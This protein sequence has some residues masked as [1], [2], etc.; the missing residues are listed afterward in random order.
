MKK[1]ILGTV[2]KKMILSLLMI[3][4]M[5]SSFLDATP[6]H[7]AVENN[8]IKTVRKLIKKGADVNSYD[9]YLQYT[10]LH[11]AAQENNVEIALYLIDHGANLDSQSYNDDIQNFTPLM[12]AAICGSV[13]VAELLLKRGADIHLK[14]SRFNMAVLHVMA[15]VTYKDIEKYDAVNMISFLIRHGANVND[16]MIEGSTPLHL[17]VMQGTMKI[18]QV[19]IVRGANV[20]SRNNE[21][22]TPLHLASKI[23]FICFA[24]YLIAYG[25]NPSCMDNKGNTPLFYAQTDE[26]R[27]LLG[28]KSWW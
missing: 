3:I 20:N 17:S 6:L 23:G 25:A 19:L 16:E 8:D 5:Q 4:G 2:M 26:M 1:I 18:A 24:Q 21:G 10:P 11:I 9:D 7:D 12:V 27:T 22:L 15:G 28:Y 13:Q 14:V